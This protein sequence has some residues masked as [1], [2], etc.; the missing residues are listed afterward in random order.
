MISKEIIACSI[1]DRSQEPDSVRE[2]FYRWKL[3][4]SG[5]RKVGELGIWMRPPD[6][7]LLRLHSISTGHEKPV[8]SKNENTL[9]L[10]FIRTIWGKKS[11][12]LSSKTRN[13]DWKLK[14][15]RPWCWV[16]SWWVGEVEKDKRRKP[17]LQH[18]VLIS[19]NDLEIESGSRSCL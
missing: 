6:R 8:A 10:A 12:C 9:G 17:V 3:R 14:Q 15:S 19:W 18:L 11:W 2:T 5:L 13:S 1:T 7:C 4:C 16:E